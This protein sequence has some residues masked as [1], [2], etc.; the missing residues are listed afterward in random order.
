MLDIPCRFIWAFQVTQSKNTAVF[1]TMLN[2]D[3][4]ALNSSKKQTFRY[5]WQEKV[6]NT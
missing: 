4:S 2:L 5:T 1:E 3:K 6:G